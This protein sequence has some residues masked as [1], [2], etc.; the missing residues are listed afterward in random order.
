LCIAS[1]IYYYHDEKRITFNST[2]TLID[3][4]VYE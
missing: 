3:L 1:G 4:F 2:A